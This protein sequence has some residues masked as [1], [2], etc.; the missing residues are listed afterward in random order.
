MAE[1]VGSD[2][3]ALGRAEIE[4]A[5]R[6]VLPIVA[7]ERIPKLYVLMDGTRRAYTHSCVVT[8]QNCV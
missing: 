2:I 8:A 5:K 3:A 4:R 1:A 6:L 7:K